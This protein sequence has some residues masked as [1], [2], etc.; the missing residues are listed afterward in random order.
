MLEQMSLKDPGSPKILPAQVVTSTMAHE[1]K[2]ENNQ[3]EKNKSEVNVQHK[4]D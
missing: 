1:S 3:S 4:P 2:K